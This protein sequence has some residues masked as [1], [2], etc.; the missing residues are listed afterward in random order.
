M[1]QE[2]S[3][4]QE[5]AS[6]INFERIL[7]AAKRRFL[8]FLIPFILV[9]AG[10]VALAMLLPAKYSSWGTVLV[11]TQQISPDLVEST[12][13]TDPDQRIRM[14]QQ[15]VMTRENLLKVIDKYNVYGEDRKVLTVSDL[16]GKMQDEIG[17]EVITSSFSGNRREETTIAFT[18]GF[19]HQNP[20]IATDVANELVTLFLSEN[21]RTRTERATEATA[22][23]AEEANKVRRQ[24]AQVEN[25]LVVYKQKYGNALPEHL[26]LRQDMLDRSETEIRDLRRDLRT[27]EEEKRYLEIELTSARSGLT[28]STGGQSE[29]A[30]NLSSLKDQLLEAST[31]LTDNHPTIIALKKRISALEQQVEEE[32]RQ[33]MASAAQGSSAGNAYNPVV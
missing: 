19:N 26:G 21:V 17:I 13:T 31:R 20:Q 28:A 18:V 15:R 29:L 25:E 3:L 9:L 1:S 6:P 16:V 22:F 32:T 5:E 12:I 23:L 10:S 24:L 4:N 2:F 33:A 30:R 8:F 14:I 27:L 11:E 7:S